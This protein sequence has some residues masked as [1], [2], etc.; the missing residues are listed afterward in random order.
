M[1]SH[2]QQSAIN[3]QQPSRIRTL[4]F[5]GFILV[6]LT[7]FLLCLQYSYGVGTTTYSLARYIWINWTENEDMGHGFLV[8]PAVLFLL[9]SERGRLLALPLRPGWGGLCVVMA[10]LFLFW[11]GNQADVTFIGLVSVMIVLAGTIWWLLGWDFLKALSFPIGFLIFAIPFPGLDMMV[12]LP[13]RFIM[14]R[15]SVVVLNLIGIPT[16]L[17]GT[18]ILSAPDASL[19]LATGQRF[20]IDVATPCS[21]IHSLFALMMVGALFAYFTMPNP[22]KKWALFLSTIP[23]AV[24]GNFA[25]ILMLTL[26]TLA[27]GSTFALGKDPLNA[28]SWFH[29]AAG[30]LVFIVALLGM[31]TIGSLLNRQ[32]GAGSGSII[33]SSPQSK[34]HEA[35]KPS[36]VDLY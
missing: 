32:W 19:N 20:A 28:P 5:A 12:A 1:P 29:L 31:M 9:Y 18:G 3:N 34:N 2:D 13:L 17:S 7:A 16:L 21:G 27:F 33:D 10:G 15:L 11:A 14:S 30:Y 24:L 35:T 6:A 4:T 26:G 36:D 8:I 22:W 23:L 25:R